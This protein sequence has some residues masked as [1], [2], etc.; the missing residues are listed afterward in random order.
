VGIL[1]ADPMQELQFLRLAMDTMKG[2][3]VVGRNELDVRK[4]I[5][6]APQR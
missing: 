6:V 3:F 1:V 2:H 4:V 5:G